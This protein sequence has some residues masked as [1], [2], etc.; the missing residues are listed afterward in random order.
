MRHASR[1]SGL[2]DVEACMTRVFQ[3]GLKTDEGTTTG[4]A[5]GTIVEVVSEVS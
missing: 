5:H 1:S 2:L 3:S 4:G